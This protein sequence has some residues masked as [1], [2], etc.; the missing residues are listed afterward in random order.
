MER[1]NFKGEK[2]KTNKTLNMPVAQNNT[3]DGGKNIWGLQKHGLIEKPKLTEHQQYFISL[4][5]I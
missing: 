1:L 3:W 2:K 4:A 5:H